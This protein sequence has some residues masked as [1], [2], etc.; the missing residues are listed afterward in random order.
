MSM[1]RYRA[2]LLDECAFWDMHMGALARLER[3]VRLGGRICKDLAKPGGKAFC[4]LTAA[5]LARRLTTF[6]S[7]RIAEWKQWAAARA[8]AN[9]GSPG[10]PD[11]SRGASS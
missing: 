2:L 8:L 10:V 1:E 9:V 7:R 11:P 6:R 3:L 5:E 4:R